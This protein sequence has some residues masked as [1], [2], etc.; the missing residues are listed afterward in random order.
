MSQIPDSPTRPKALVVDDH[1]DA[2]RSLEMMLQSFGY[3]TEVA[4]DGIDG[5]RKATTFQPDLMLLDISMP[6]LDG[7]DT[8]GVI[9]AQ[10][11]AAKV[12]LVAVT[13][14]DPQQLKERSEAAGFDAYLLKPVEFSA[15]EKVARPA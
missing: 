2:A 5:L 10:P 4:F 1:E 11:W 15:L 3:D 14:W 12:R 8:C 9:R 13:G 7:Y 6:K